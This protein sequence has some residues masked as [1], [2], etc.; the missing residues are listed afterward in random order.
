MNLHEDKNLNK[1]LGERV[2][3]SWRDGSREKEGI[4]LFNRH[5]GMYIL[6]ASQFEFCSE[7]LFR[8]SHVKKIERLNR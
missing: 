5:R 4:L 1:Y 7:L 3:I 2:R 8:K 6:K